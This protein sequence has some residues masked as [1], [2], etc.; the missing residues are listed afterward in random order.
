M[1]SEEQLKEEIGFLQQN[2]RLK[3]S[4][5]ALLNNAPPQAL[6]RS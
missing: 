2:L 5:D 6:G 1:L 4:M 3:A